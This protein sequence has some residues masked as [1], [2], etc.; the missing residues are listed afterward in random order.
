MVDWAEEEVEEEA[1]V[2]PGAAVVVLEEVEPA[3]QEEECVLQLE[4]LEVQTAQEEPER[5]R[6]AVC[7]ICC[8]RWS[9]I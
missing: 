9:R 3:E 1:A 4:L 6:V 2:V 5:Q 8:K 7:V